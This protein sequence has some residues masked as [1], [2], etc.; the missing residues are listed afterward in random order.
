MKTVTMLGS[1]PRAESSERSDLTTQGRSPGQTGAARGKTGSD[2]G[3][4]GSNRIRQGADRVRQRSAPG[5]ESS[6]R[7]DLTTKHGL[8]VRQE[9]GKRSDG[10]GRE[11][12]GSYG[13]DR[14]IR[15]H[16]AVGQTGGR[17]KQTK[18]SCRSE[19]AFY[20]GVGRW[21]ITTPLWGVVKV[22]GQL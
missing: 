19:G 21:F 20:T 17:Q 1:A 16:A 9:D 13:S 11:R 15:G 22:R 5:A 12:K 2:R 14:S 4:T 8:W 10:T 6:E 18:D 7:S 3:Q